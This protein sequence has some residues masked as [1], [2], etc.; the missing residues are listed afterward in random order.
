MVVLLAACLLN[1]QTPA[2]SLREHVKFLADDKLE[3]RDTPSKGLDL[4]ADYIAKEF[5]QGGAK[6]GVK[7][8]Y[9]QETEY[10]NRRTQIKA[11]VRNVIAILPGTDDKLKDKYI[12]VS[13][14]YDHLGKREGEGDQIFNGAN[15]NA[16]STAGIIEIARSLSKTKLR[17]TVVFIAF[18]GEEKGLVGAR[19]Y[20]QNP[21][22]PIAKTE[23][24][25][26]IE[27]IGRTDDSE[28]PRVSTFN[29][30]GF[31]Y[32]NLPSILAPA[33]SKFGVK[34]VKHEKFS[35][36]YFSA[37]DNAAFAQ[38]G[39]PSGTISV[40]YQFADYHKV[41]DHWDK[42]DYDNMAKIVAAITQGV[43]DLANAE[44][45]IEWNK[46]NPKTERYRKLRD[47]G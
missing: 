47:G 41:G 26:N 44:K 12:I 2:A 1:L 14:H 3:G 15:D 13:A 32:T 45:P 35:D 29:L 39:V 42:L 27:Q 36:P 9:F 17:R 18:Y 40:A 7:D 24:N 28:G 25:L 38:V 10:E 21:I 23:V 16:S 22:F 31:D 6:P 5:K 8:S 30:T 46:E 34:V 20:A 11:P 19:Y 4:A 43:S 37:S 33:A